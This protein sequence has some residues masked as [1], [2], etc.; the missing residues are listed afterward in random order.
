MRCLVCRQEFEGYA[1]PR[2][3]FPVVESPDADTLLENI[4]EQVEAYREEFLR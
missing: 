4:G 2:C 1:C 3:G